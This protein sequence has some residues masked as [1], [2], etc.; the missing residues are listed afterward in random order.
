MKTLVLRRGLDSSYYFYLSIFARANDL[1]LLVD[2]RIRERR[3]A[4]QSSALERR[5]GDRRREAVVS[6][7]DVDL[8][9]VI[10]S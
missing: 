1:E 2:R 4:A 5:G 10:E 3:S 8:L 7:P 9:F 6:D